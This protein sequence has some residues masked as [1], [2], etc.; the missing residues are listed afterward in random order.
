[1]SI[2]CLHHNDA[3]GRASAAIV[4]RAL[5]RDVLL[6]EIDFG[7][8]VPWEKIDRAQRVIM[9][10]FSLPPDDM[11]RLADSTELIW[12]DHHISALEAMAG[13]ADDWPGL[14]DISEAGCVLTWKY[15]FPG[16]PVPR[17]IILIGDR[18]IWRWAEAETGS[19][20]EGLHQR[21]TRPENDDLW[22][23]LLEDDHQL[24]QELIQEG[25]ILRRARLLDV[26]RY[27]RKY[28]FE[29]SFE[30]YRTLAVN[31]R[32]SG[33]MGAYIRQQG[34][35]VAYCYMDVWQNDRLMTT[36]TLYSEQVD[37]SK[38]A[39]KFGG[40]GHRGAA[41]FSFQRGATPFPLSAK[42]WFG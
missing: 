41:G 26:R 25:E 4:R 19:F 8:P 42:V 9:V 12:V 40:G 38:L 30:G 11:Q 35:Q 36:V 22:Q 17:A 24:L 23:P 37:V 3:D 7:E 32:S 20:D 16:L 21:D 2:I 39:Q 13:I 34:Y 18:D 15:F 5:G 33:E 31:A 6:V 27:V 28:G 1:M 29:L 14:R 10:D